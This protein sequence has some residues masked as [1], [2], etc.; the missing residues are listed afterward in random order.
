MTY[1]YPEGLLASPTTDSAIID[2]SPSSLDDDGRVS[3]T[4]LLGL[5]NVVARMKKTSNRKTRSVIDDDE[6]DE[7]IFELLLIAIPQLFYWL[8]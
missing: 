6:N 2:G 3:F 1:L 8:V 4:A 5:I 7:S